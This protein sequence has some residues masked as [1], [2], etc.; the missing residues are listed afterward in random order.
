MGEIIIWN[1]FSWWWLD[2]RWNLQIN[3]TPNT[4]TSR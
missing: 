3:H 4:F 2:Q 1:Y